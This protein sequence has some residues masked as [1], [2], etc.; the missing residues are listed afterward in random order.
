MNKKVVRILTGILLSFLVVLTISTCA[1]QTSG[2]NRANIQVLALDAEVNENEKPPECSR[3]ETPQWLP[4]K[5]QWSCCPYV[6]NPFRFFPN[7]RGP[8]CDP[9]PTN[10]TEN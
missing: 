7:A 6:W 10:N 8:I 9:P 1:F 4:E 3:D 2:T 5:Q